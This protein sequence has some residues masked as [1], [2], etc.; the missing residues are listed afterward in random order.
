MPSSYPTQWMI[1]AQI[2]A[3]GMCKWEEVMIGKKY[4]AE[5]WL[6]LVV[7]AF[8]K[9]IIQKI[10]SFACYDPLCSHWQLR[11]SACPSPIL[12]ASALLHMYFQ[13]SYYLL[14]LRQ[15]P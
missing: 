7:T 13:S 1:W 9:P 8:I 4:I 14:L 3:Y 11:P 6:S 2:P 15:L 10:V 12:A 5:S